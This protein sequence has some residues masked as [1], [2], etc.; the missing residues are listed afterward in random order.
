MRMPPAGGYALAVLALVA[1]ACGG[2]RSRD[3]GGSSGSTGSGRDTPIQTS[4]AQP[5]TPPATSPAAPSTGT[6]QLT[7]RGTNG[8][9]HVACSGVDTEFAVSGYGGPIVWTAEAR[10]R[11]PSRWPYDGNAVSSIVAQPSSGVLAEGQRAIVHVSGTFPSGRFYVA[12]SA[13]NR[14]G[15]GFGTLEFSCQ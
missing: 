3:S 8:H 1:L 7:F 12:V 5:G 13:P 11:M 9:D 10:D 14:T 6:V 15:H 4:P 2:I